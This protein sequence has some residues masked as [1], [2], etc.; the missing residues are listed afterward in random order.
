M[1]LGVASIV[2]IAYISVK[3]L[4]ALERLNKQVENVRYY[5]G[6]METR[7]QRMAD[8]LHGI[9]HHTARAVKDAYDDDDWK[10]RQPPI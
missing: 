6:E 4:E 9:E 1:G 10:E 3:I 8:K 7:Q 5:L 2:A